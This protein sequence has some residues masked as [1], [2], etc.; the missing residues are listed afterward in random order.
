MLNYQPSRRWAK[1]TTH[2]DGILKVRGCHM[3]DVIRAGLESWLH[4][5]RPDFKVTRHIQGTYGVVFVLQ[6]KESNVSPQRFCV[7]TL[8]PEKLKPG[9]RD[10][11]R[12]FQREMRL[13]LKMPFH[14]HVLP[15]L[16]LEFAPPPAALAGDL[17]ALPLVRMPFC[18]ANLAACITGEINMSLPD[19]LIVLAQ[20]CS[21]LRWLYEHGIEGHGDLK[22]DNIL[23]RD[24]RRCFELPHGEGFPSRAHPWQARVADLGWADIWIQGG[25]TYHAWR[26]YLAPERFHNAVVPGASD[27]FAVVVMACE[28]LSGHHPAGD[29][30]KRLAEKWSSS[31]WEAWATSGRRKLEFEPRIVRDL[32]A[33]ALAPDPS[34]RPSVWELESALCDILLKEYRVNLAAQLSSL[35][36]QARRWDV[37]THSA[38]AAGE[39]ARVNNPQLDQSI[40]EL[41]KQLAELER[42]VDDRSAARWVIQARTLQRLLRRRGGPGDCPRAVALAREVLERLLVAGRG[43]AAL[44]EE[45]YG[46]QSQGLGIAREEVVLEFAHEAFRTLREAVGAGLV[47]EAILERYGAPMEQLVGVV[48]RALRECWSQRGIEVDE[49]AMEILRRDGLLRGWWESFWSDAD[50]EEID[51]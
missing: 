23:L 16:G 30:T 3:I 27:I 26:P 10:V 39:M 32:V 13:W 21:G 44:V 42:A 19:R 49:R 35:D 8:N 48:F 50:S 17:E 38:W 18:E 20:L 9:G 40:A 29:I 37:V 2:R 14:P 34:A 5:R 41:Q 28:L 51:Q 24:L 33:S 7:K 43:I 47:E 46:V 6:A 1:Y 11:K 45:A 4:N 36:Q 12:L 31:K 25:G 22:P 15:A